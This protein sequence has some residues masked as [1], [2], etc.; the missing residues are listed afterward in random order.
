MSLVYHSDDVYKDLKRRIIEEDLRPGDVL[1][2]R[3][4]SL[5]YN[6]SRT[7]AR[8]AL[9]QLVSDGL[10]VLIRG[11]GYSVR[12]LSV[13]DIIEVFVARE[14]IEG[15]LANLSASHL[16]AEMQHRLE[17]LKNEMEE[18]NPEISPEKVIETGS[19]LHNLI[20]ETAHNTMLYKFYQE[21][22][23]VAALT[24]NLSKYTSKIESISRDEHIL[25]INSLIAGNREDAEGYMRLHLRRTC[26][27]IVSSYLQKRTTSHHFLH[28]TEAGS[29]L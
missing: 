8:E 11:R 25:I 13:E 26:E 28:H 27:R 14:S 9:R 3:D 21:L 6:V 29:L 4:V 22:C 18:I 1:V 24:R 16:N 10:V 15:T 19:R 5:N 7:P 23:T 17:N 20:A 12:Q 2:E